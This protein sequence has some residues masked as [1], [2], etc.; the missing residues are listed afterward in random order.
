M[1]VFV[2]GAGGFVGR[3]FCREALARGHELL[4]LSR[5]GRIPELDR[6][7]VA[8]GD[9]GTVPWRDVERFS[10]DALLH[11]AWIAAPGEYLDSPRNAL[12]AEQSSSMIADATR[13]GVSHVAAVGT[14]IE[15]APSHDPLSEKSSAIAPE[16]PYSIAKHRLHT[17]LAERYRGGDTTWS[18]LRIFHAYGP[19]EHPERLPTSFA[20]QLAC[21]APVR[22]RTPSSVRDFIH[23]S[24]LA[25]ALCAALESRL[26]GAVNLGTG[27][28]ASIRRLAEIVAEAVGASAE[29]VVEADAAAVDARPIVVADSSR[30]RS[31][32]WSPSV[33]LAEG[34]RQLVSSLALP[35]PARSSLSQ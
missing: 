9:L 17:W 5:R 13:R 3:A 30:I 10:P 22:L 15:Y 26:E 29:L 14:C 18:W 23:I 2:T 4:C 24:D 12:L 27:E 21:G 20:M 19:G 8:V 32:G 1:K 6:A 28:G 7:A 11:L 34:I 33:P 35:C 16:F 31:T 25:R